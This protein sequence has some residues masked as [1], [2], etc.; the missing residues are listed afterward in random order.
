VAFGVVIRPGVVLV[1]HSRGSYVNSASARC[2]AL[3]AV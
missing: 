2:R 3:S 1:A